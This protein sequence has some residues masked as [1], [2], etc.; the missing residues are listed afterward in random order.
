MYVQMMG[1]ILNVQGMKPGNKAVA[2][3]KRGKKIEVGEAAA[4]N[5]F[6]PSK[7]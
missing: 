7:T 3:G 1:E 6:C 4:V 2:S 5:F